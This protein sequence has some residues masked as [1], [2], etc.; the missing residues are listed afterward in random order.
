MKMKL[1]L[2]SVL[3]SLWI[4]VWPAHADATVTDDVKKVVAEVVRIVSNKDLKKP[5]NEEKRRTELKKAI[6]SIFDYGQMAKLSMGTHWKER[7]PAEQKEFEKLFETLLENTY[8]TKIEAYNNDKIVYVRETVVGN[9]V[10]VISRVFTAQEEEYTLDYRLAKK[11]NE[12]LVYDVVIEGVSLVANYRG[13]FNHII[14]TQ[15]YDELVKQLRTK[16]AEIKAP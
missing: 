15:G 13:Q 3:L 5:Q 4:A 11:N 6:G 14:Q 10:E 12:W 16:N 8:A 1:L 7:A 9:H 2:V